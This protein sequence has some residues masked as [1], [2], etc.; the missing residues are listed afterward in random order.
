MEQKETR[1]PGRKRRTV[2]ALVAVLLLLLI[3]V[4]SQRKPIARNFVDRE[5]RAR[6]VPARY[7]ITDLGFGRQR[8]TGLVIGDPAAPELTAD[9]VELR[10]GYGFGWPRLRA[11]TARG[12]RLR[13][14]ACRRRSFARQRGPPAPRAEWRAVRAA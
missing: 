6:G 2:A 8:L 5:L 13:G 10:I 9:T 7:V 3:G 4:W 11:V 1:P 12:V 14:R